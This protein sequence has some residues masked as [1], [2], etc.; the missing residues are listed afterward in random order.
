MK[1]ASPNETSKS[2]ASDTSAERTVPS[3][4]HPG[5]WAALG[6]TTVL[7]VVIDLVSKWLAFRHIADAPVVVS[8]AEVL[9]ARGRLDGLIPPHEPVVVVPSVL[10][11]S[12]VLNPGAVFGMGAGQ[13]WFF[14]IFTGVAIGFGLWMFARWTTPRDRLA[15]VALGLV[16]G[17][18][19]GNLYDRLVFGCVRDFLHP[20]P[21]VVWP[22]GVRWPGGG[23]EI[24]PYVSN[25]ADLFLLIGIAML[26]WHI[27]RAGREAERAPDVKP[28]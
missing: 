10:N 1:R 14:I 6:I 28:A 11:F 5:A 12:L 8:R 4:R 21:G 27:W 17:G 16:L 2:P 15:H 19:L 22:F 3:F 9:A 7:A 26:M 23:R 25:L 18:G 24:W 13:R 20:L